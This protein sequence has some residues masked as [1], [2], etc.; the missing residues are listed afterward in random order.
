MNRYEVTIRI[1]V[2]VDAPDQLETHIVKAHGF[3]IQMEEATEPVLLFHD[4]D[5]SYL[6]AFRNN[7]QMVK[8]VNE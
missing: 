6:V 1:Y 7:W 8:E 5:G 4:S 3:N 2:S